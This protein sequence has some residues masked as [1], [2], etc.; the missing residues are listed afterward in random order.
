MYRPKAIHM[1]RAQN[2]A[3]QSIGFMACLL[4]QIILV[5]DRP[6]TVE[7]VLSMDFRMFNEIADRFNQT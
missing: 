6:Q 2:A 1:M 3:Q 5:D 7:E 4:S